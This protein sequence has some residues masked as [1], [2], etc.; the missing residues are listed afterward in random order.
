MRVEIM[1]LPSYTPTISDNIG[2]E[3][4]TAKRVI[5]KGLE[6]LEM[7]EGNDVIILF[8]HKRENKNNST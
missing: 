5:W 6:G 2:H 3:F 8:K 4:E 7:E 1:L